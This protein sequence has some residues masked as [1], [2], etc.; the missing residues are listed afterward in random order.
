MSLKANLMA[1]AQKLRLHLCILTAILLGLAMVHHDLPYPD[2]V[3][4]ILPPLRSPIQ[5]QSKLGWTQLYQGHILHWWVQA[6]DEIHPELA[7]SSEQVMTQLLC[8]RWTDILDLWKTH[9]THLHHQADQLDLP[10]YQ[11]AIITL[12]EWRHQLPPDAQEA[13]YQQPLEVVLE[14]P[15][16][17]LQTYA[18]RG[19]NYFN[20]QLKAA[21]TQACLNTLDICTFFGCQPQPPNDLQPPQA[22]LLHWT[23]VGLLCM[24]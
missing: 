2:I 1:A 5:C 23:S 9:N 13:L 11:Q 14:Q 12:Y 24:Q 17:W 10:N 21:K 7:L 22:T 18:Q 15:T 19:L 8:I 20:R 4:E 16:P 3:N 6:I